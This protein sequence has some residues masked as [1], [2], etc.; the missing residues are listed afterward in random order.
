MYDLPRDADSDRPRDSNQRFLDHIK[1]A[2]I[3][4]VRDYRVMFEPKLVELQKTGVAGNV[5]AAAAPSENPPVV[6]ACRLFSHV[7]MRTQRWRFSGRPIY[8]WIKPKDF[9]RQPNDRQASDASSPAS[10]AIELVESDQSDAIKEFEAE[11]FFDRDD[12]DCEFTR[13]RLTGGR[14]EL[15]SCPWELPSATYFRHAFNFVSRYAGAMQPGQGRPLWPSRPADWSHRVAILADAP[16]LEVTRPQMRC[17]VPLTTSPDDA[18]PCA[19]APDIEQR[20]LAPT[21]P[22]ACILEER[23]FAVGGLAERMLGEIVTGVGYG[24]DGV[25]NRVHPRDFGKETSRDG[26]LSAWG[27]SPPT[28]FT[29]QPNPAR[30]F[31]VETE[32]PIGLHFEEVTTPSPAWSNCQYL[33]RPRSLR[34]R[35]PLPE[36]SF[37]AVQ[38]RRFLDPDWI[39]DAKPAARAQANASAT[40]TPSPP[41]DDWPLSLPCIARHSLATLANACGTLASVTLDGSGSMSLIDFEVRESDQ[42]SPGSIVAFARRTVLG[43]NYPEGS[44]PLCEIPLPASGVAGEAGELA[45]LHIPHGDGSSTISIALVPADDGAADGRANVPLIVGTARWTLAHLLATNPSDDAATPSPQAKAAAIQFPAVNGASPDVRATSMSQP[46]YREW[47]R[48][49]KNADFVTAMTNDGQDRP[50]RVGGI[51]ARVI[52]RNRADAKPAATMLEF[53]LPAG[54]D[55]PEIERTSLWLCGSLANSRMPLFVHRYLV[56]VFSSA[57]SSGGRTYR[58]FS[59]ASLL[60]DRRPW[61]PAAADGDIESLTLHEM[62]VP[63]Q[64]VAAGQ[65]LPKNLARFKTATIDLKATGG[66]PADDQTIAYRLHVR[67]ANSK[68]SMETTTATVTV[69]TP[70]R[71]ITVNVP[72]GIQSLDVMWTLGPKASANNAPGTKVFS[73]LILWDCL[74]KTPPPPI[75]TLSDP[76]KP[77]AATAITVTLENVS[78]PTELWADVSL[79]HRPVEKNSQVGPE[80]FNAFTFDWLFSSR[81]TGDD[82]SPASRTLSSTLATRVEAQGRFVSSSQPIVI[83]PS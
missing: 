77:N 3:P 13:V 43:A 2:T 65:V 14:D 27:W 19:A 79:L 9:R 62:E 34:D 6:P 29:D 68:A 39:F 50:I 17:I 66:L 36:E 52:P 25:D 59:H 10:P 33:L 58:S 8:R 1:I 63:A 78:G 74:K 70:D 26:R 55:I 53:R 80:D 37:L 12:A 32:G 47:T 45:L 38:L 15:L 48:T 31:I 41:P 81:D 42:T 76:L 44:L 4:H 16:R 57:S 18:A 75:T 30:S 64:I 11:I 24:F 54:N 35:Q 72:Q 82:R 83:D 67:F 5:D 40:T 73:R 71:T 69:A 60:G 28:G 21:A 7:E 51:R 49:S 61:L 20:R 23:P 56:G 46:T 22:V